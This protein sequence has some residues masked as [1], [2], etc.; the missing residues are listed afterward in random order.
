MCVLLHGT[1]NFQP[2]HLPGIFFGGFHLP[3]PWHQ[4]GELRMLDLRGPMAP[5]GDIPVNVKQ[6]VK[7]ALYRKEIWK[8]EKSKFLVVYSS[9]DI[10]F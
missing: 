5:N 7:P 3:I 8:N 6:M 9:E 2:G 1:A 10:F 4:N